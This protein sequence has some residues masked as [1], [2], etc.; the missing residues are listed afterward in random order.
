MSSIQQ[1]ANLAKGLVIARQVKG[2]VIAQAI[3]QK[4]THNLLLNGSQLAKVKKS[5]PDMSLP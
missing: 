4:L 3:D 5:I 1:F 2:L